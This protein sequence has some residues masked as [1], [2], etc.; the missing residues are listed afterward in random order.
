MNH[1][2]EIAKMRAAR[3]LWDKLIKEF[4]V[5]VIK[6][7]LIPSLTASKEISRILNNILYQKTGTY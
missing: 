5:N 1:F 4:K 7:G 6:I 3:F 2:M